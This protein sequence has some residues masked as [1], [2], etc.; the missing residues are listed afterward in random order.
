M[1][2]VLCKSSN[3]IL[4]ELLRGSPDGKPHF[5]NCLYAEFASAAPSVIDLNNEDYYKHIR[6]GT[7]TDR[8]FLRLPIASVMPTVDLY[9]KNKID[10]TFQA[11]LSTSQSAGVAGSSLSGMI[12]YG[13]ALVN[14]PTLFSSADDITQDIV[15]ARGYFDTNKQIPASS[16]ASHSILFTLNLS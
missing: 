13:C 1:Q 4:A 15:W 5:L 11:I 9:D 10:L 14:A 3:R 6:N 2:T 12:F 8:D 16:I 7:I